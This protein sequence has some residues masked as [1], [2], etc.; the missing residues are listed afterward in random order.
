[1]VREKRPL[2]NGE[3]QTNAVY[4]GLQEGFGSLLVMVVNGAAVPGATTIAGACGWR[5]TSKPATL[6]V[7][8]DFLAPARPRAAQDSRQLK[9]PLP[10]FSPELFH[11]F[12]QLL[13]SLP[14][15]LRNVVE[16]TFRNLPWKMVNSRRENLS[17]E[18]SPAHFCLPGLD[19]LRYHNDNFLSF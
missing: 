10:P 6:I 3:N 13:N 15:F 4:M 14:V 8:P 1:M 7:G 17:P 12:R 18:T 9:S 2:S 11:V 16:T 19:R 5:S